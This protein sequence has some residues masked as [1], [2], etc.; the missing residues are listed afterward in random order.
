MDLAI[1]IWNDTLRGFKNNPNT[2]TVYASISDTWN[3]KITPAIIKDIKKYAKS[4][5]YKAEVELSKFN[6]LILRK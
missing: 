4:L 3:N 1:Q 5:G 6:W 2:I